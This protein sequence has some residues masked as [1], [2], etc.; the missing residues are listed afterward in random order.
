MQGRTLIAYITAGGATETYANVI[1]ETLRSRGRDVDV[2]DLKR[3][4]VGDLAGYSNVILGTGV[5]MFMVYR[6]G[7]SFLAR[8]DLKGK[9]LG[10]FLSSAMAI[11]KPDEARKR[12]LDPIIRKHGLSPLMCDAFPGKDPQGPGKLVDRTDAGTA[13]RWAERFDALVR[14]A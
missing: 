6:K 5:R 1:A 12:F 4:K 8:R 9:P 2:V 14:E 10:V 13:R 7:K 11:E 3:E